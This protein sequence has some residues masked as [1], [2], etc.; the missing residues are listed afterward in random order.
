MELIKLGGHGLALTRMTEDYR[1][2]S[3][4]GSRREDC[5]VHDIRAT[6]KEEVEEG[7]KHTRRLGALDLVG[8]W[9]HGTQLRRYGNSGGRYAETHG[10]A[11]VHSM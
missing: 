8:T 7:E 11:R 6:S 1:D 3:G 10:L 4:S 9:L 5:L 2:S